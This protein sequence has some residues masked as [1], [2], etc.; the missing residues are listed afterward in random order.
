[1]HHCS[2]YLLFLLDA[3][4]W[5]AYAE[6]TKKA[7]HVHPNNCYQRICQAFSDLCWRM[8]KPNSW[9]PILLRSIKV[10]VC[11]VFFSQHRSHG[12]GCFGITGLVFWT[13]GYWKKGWMCGRLLFLWE[14]NWKARTKHIISGNYGWQKW[15]TEAK[16]SSSKW[17]QTSSYEWA[18]NNVYSFKTGE[19]Q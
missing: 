4:H 13:N 18:C 1:M 15:P 6:C 19:S 10:R 5:Q 14:V 12:Y 11:R 3:Q 9:F 16:M 17:Q 8:Y 7:Q 2:S